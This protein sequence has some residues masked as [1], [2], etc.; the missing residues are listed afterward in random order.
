MPNPEAQIASKPA[1][2]I[3]LALRASWAPTVRIMPGRAMRARRVVAWFM[4]GMGCYGAREG[5]MKSMG[6]YKQN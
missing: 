6:N 5:P 2:S 4:G 3:S 1:R